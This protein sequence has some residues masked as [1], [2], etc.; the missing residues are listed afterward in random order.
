MKN[1][2][3]MCG[4]TST[5]LRRTVRR[6]GKTT[7][8][9]ITV[10]LMSINTALACRIFQCWQTDW[11]D[12][13]IAAQCCEQPVSCC[14]GDTAETDNSPDSGSESQPVPLIESTPAEVPDTPTTVPPTVSEPAETVD[15]VTEQP[16]PTFDPVDDLFSGEPAIVEPESVADPIEVTPLVDETPIDPIGDLSPDIDANDINDILGTPIDSNENVAEPMDDIDALFGDTNE[17]ATTDP[18]E[19]ILGTPAT[20]ETTPS[21]DLGTPPD[22]DLNDIFGDPGTGDPG[23]SDPDI[24]TFDP[25]IPETSPETDESPSGEEEVDL[26]DLFGSV[27]PSDKDDAG[28]RN[29]VDNTGLYKVQA[30]LVT[31]RHNEIRLIKANGRKTTVAIRRL[32]NNDLRYVQQQIAKFGYGAVEKI[33]SR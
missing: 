18:I 32:S 25:I 17:P 15:P 7:V 16:L 14:D 13:P 19:D 5:M 22:N 20:D 6:F 1:K 28:M 26:D 11:C 3:G 2:T 4:E 30:R 33:A 29:W 23:T 9:G 27:N 10:V 24:P 21:L 8:V 12:R 31:I